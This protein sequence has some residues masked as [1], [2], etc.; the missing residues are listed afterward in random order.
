MWT[1]ARE[2]TRNGT[3]KVYSYYYNNHGPE[4]EGSGHGSDVPFA[5]QTL[6]GRRAPS[7]QDLALS[8]LISTYFVN[9]AVTGN[10]NGEGLPNWPAFT[11]DENEVMVFDA[12]PG[13]RTY[14]ALDRVEIY[15]PFFD[16][17]RE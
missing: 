10:P 12:K 4:A 17:M 6:A 2:Q 13:A 14:P 5:F 15:D 7:Q 9:F 8:D 3:G 1:W 16:S 11:S